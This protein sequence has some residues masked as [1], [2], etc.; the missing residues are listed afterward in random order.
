MRVIL[1][2]W[3]KDP[4]P[5]HE[6]YNSKLGRLVYSLGWL[7]IDAYLI[8]IACGALLFYLPRSISVIVAVVVGIVLIF[9]WRLVKNHY[10]VST[11]LFKFKYTSTPVF[12]I[13][14]IVCLVLVIKA[15]F[16]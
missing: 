7:N 2:D 5:Q 13:I 8:A 12:D 4:L 3:R 6:R 9:S 14:F 15:L 16:L 10:G 1:Y 11:G